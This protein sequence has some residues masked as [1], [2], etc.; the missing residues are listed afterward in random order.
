MY[1]NR[2][3]YFTLKLI[4]TILY[5]SQYISGLYMLNSCYNY[6]TSP[7]KL[8]KH[9]WKDIWRSPSQPPFPS[10]DVLKTNRHN[11]FRI[12]EVNLQTAARQK[13]KKKTWPKNTFSPVNTPPYLISNN[14][15]GA[16]TRY[17]FLAANDAKFYNQFDELSTEHISQC[18]VRCVEGATAMPPVR[19]WN[20][21]SQERRHQRRRRDVSQ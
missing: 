18:K 13:R 15:S 6:Q 19:R 16:G 11:I 2:Y 14:V 5:I 20:C 8:S 10:F 17:F 9:L 7:N 4:F 1:Y 3:F 12:R 21:Y